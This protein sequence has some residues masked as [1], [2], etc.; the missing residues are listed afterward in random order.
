MKASDVSGTIKVPVDWEPRD[1]QLPIWKYMEDGGKRAVAVWHR[2]AGK[3]LFAINFIAWCAC[4]RVGLYWHMLPK[5]AQGR[6]VAWE[7][8]TREGKKFLDAFPKQLIDG[9]PNN[10]EMRLRLKNG[11]IYQVVGSDEPDRLVG[12][13]PIGCVF[14][15]YSISDP[16]CWDFMRPILAENGGWA[17]FIFTPRGK[18]HG[19]DI[20]Q[21]AKGNPKWFSQTL[22]VEDTKAID[23]SLIEED[24]AS[25]MPEEMI[26]QEYYV[27]FEAPLVGAYYA[28][29]MEKMEKDGR[30]GSIP[31]EPRLEVHTAWDLGVGD[32]TAILFY[33]MVGQEIRVI[34]FYSNS[35]EG[36]THYAKVVKEKDYV[37]GRHYAPHDIEVREFTTGKS[38][39][40]TARGLGIRFTV[41][42]KLSVEDGIDA[43]RNILP[44]MWVDGVRCKEL[45]RAM[46]EYRKEWDEK[47]K[48]YRSKPLH[49]WAS[50]M[51]DALRYMAIGLRS[52]RT[53]EK[54]PERA[55][56]EWSVFSY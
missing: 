22:T 19:W 32:S 4:Q 15:E 24:R 3:D 30:V 34:D 37:Y 44:R 31:Y 28:V 33:Q 27:S 17:M 39:L 35:G 21:Q 52:A 43:V 55:E 48:C 25:G 18:N 9:E 13:N 56:S 46:R 23:M 6:K 42:P 54:L 16:S 36:L 10:N 53:K 11:S 14:S 49:D 45:L 2:R 20:L 51:C 5:Y 12:A 1:Y 47:N 29:Q 38:R 26:Q 7:G 8:M 41:L 50:D 40:E